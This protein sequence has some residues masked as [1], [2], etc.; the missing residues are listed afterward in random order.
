MTV[1]ATLPDVSQALE[2][3]DRLLGQNLALDQLSLLSRRSLG[4]RKDS[5]QIPHFGQIWGLGRLSQASAVAAAL[6]L[7]GRLGLES[8]LVDMPDGLAE[9]IRARL[10]VGAAVMEVSVPGALDGSLLGAM[11]SAH[12]AQILN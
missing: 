12:G 6:S 8:V 11:L 9:Q 7:D 5:L 1:Y 10:E 3:F 4:A 2:I